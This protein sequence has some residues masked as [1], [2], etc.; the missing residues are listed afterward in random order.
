MDNLLFQKIWEDVDFYEIKVKAYNDNVKAETELY[1][2]N[3]SIISL[4][5]NIKDLVKAPNNN[6]YWEIGSRDLSVESFF[7][8]RKVAYDNLGHFQFEVNIG[9]Q[10]DN[11]IN[12]YCLFPI[13]AEIGLLSQFGESVLLLNKDNT[14][15]SIISLC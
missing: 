5:N 7:S 4:S 15:E 8:L 12:Y 13:S 14:F 1:V 3:K 11:N 2:N 6:F 10:N 9:I